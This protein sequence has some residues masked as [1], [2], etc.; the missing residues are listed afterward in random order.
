MYRPIVMYVAIFDVIKLRVTWI[1]LYWIKKFSIKC[2]QLNSTSINRRRWNTSMYRITHYR[3]Q[4]N[5]VVIKSNHR[6]DAAIPIAIYSDYDLILPITDVADSFTCIYLIYG[7]HIVFCLYVYDCC[8]VDLFVLYCSFCLIYLIFVLVSHDAVNIIHGQSAI[9]TII[10]A[11]LLS[12]RRYW[13]VDVIGDFNVE[14]SW[15]RV[16]M[17]GYLLHEQVFKGDLQA[18]KK[19]LDTEDPSQKDAHGNFS[20]LIVWCNWIRKY[21]KLETGKRCRIVLTVSGLVRFSFLVAVVCTT[22]CYLWVL[23]WQIICSLGC[24]IHNST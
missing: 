17:D 2:T 11:V 1:E 22:R 18:V 3:N 19:L 8:V 16:V 5:W 14:S 9:Y 21:F 4:S 13:I 10:V 15:R 24:Q 6:W 7:I 23:P 20:I 12:K